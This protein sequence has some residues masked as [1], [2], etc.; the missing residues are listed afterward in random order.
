MMLNLE[1]VRMVP[2]LIS[3]YIPVAVVAVVACGSC[4]GCLLHTTVIPS[5]LWKSVTSCVHPA[6]SPADQMLLEVR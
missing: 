1:Y 3:C 5:N 2:L 6:S 4:L